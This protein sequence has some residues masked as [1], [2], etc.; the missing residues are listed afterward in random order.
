ML[1]HLTARDSLL[2]LADES[3]SVRSHAVPVWQI[4][5][6]YI[7][8]EGHQ[9]A[10]RLMERDA[11]AAYATA[12]A[13]QLTGKAGYADKAA[14]LI[15]GWA[16]VNVGFSDND[17]PLVSAYIGSGLI[18][19]ARRIRAYEGWNADQ[20]DRFVR[21]TTTVCLPAWDG[22]P[23]RNNWWSWSLYAQLCFYRFLEDNEA[24]RL[25]AQQL[26]AHI[27]ESLDDSGFIPEETVR[28]ANG[29][30]YH[31]FSLAPMTAAAKIVADATGEDLFRWVSPNGKSLK[32]ALDTLFFYVDG[33]VEQWPFDKG[34]NMP[35]RI[36][37]D[38]WPVELYEAMALVYGDPD[39]V[40]F[41]APHRPVSGHK[42]PSS[43]NF[44]SYAW[45]YPELE[46]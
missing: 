11:Q 13:Y 38:T 26:K 8:K 45:F 32:K 31:Y 22:I 46:G 43:G 33:R 37:G 44:Q 15:D 19:A 30:W 36:A 7:D 42:N 25:E 41:A 2:V 14:E 21:W 4:P 1:Q 40:R 28:G 27:D 18:R 24:I 6:F 5:G 9:T 17:G 16:S 10:K 35:S 29:M 20:R 12:I 39:Y 34:Q 23:G 3:M